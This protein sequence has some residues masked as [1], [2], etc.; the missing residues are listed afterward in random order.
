M[1]LDFSS[2]WSIKWAQECYEFV[3]NIQTTG[4]VIQPFHTVA[5]DIYIGQ[6]DQSAVWI[7]CTLKILLLTYL[8]ARFSSECH[9]RLQALWYEAHYQDAERARG[10]RLGAVHKYRVR[11]RNP[12]PTT[13]CS[14]RSSVHCF[15]ESTRNILRHWYRANPYPN[16]AAKRRL[17]SLSGLT[18]TQVRPVADPGVSDQIKSKWLKQKDQDGH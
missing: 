6:W 5:E 13:I 16:P 4:R 17:A 10:H 8:R 15:H 12:P 9:T 14:G 7:N 2:F 11:K 3:L 1:R 18:P